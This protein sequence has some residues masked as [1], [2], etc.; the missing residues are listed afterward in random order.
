MDFSYGYY[1]S[2]CMLSR[3]LPRRM[4]YALALS[5]ADRYFL[6]DHAGREAVRSNLRTVLGAGGRTPGDAEISA[7]ARNTFRSFGKYLVDFF[8]YSWLSD[9]QVRR[10]FEIE[11]P[12]HLETALAM[13][14][15][16]LGVSA[17][18]GNWELSGPLL[19]ANGHRLSA[20]VLP[21][22]A[23]KVDR[24]LEKY[25]MR[26]GT[27]VLPLGR[28]TTLSIVG[29]LRRGDV[30][31]LMADKDFT[32]SDQRVPF[33]GRAARLPRGPAYLAV[34]TG[35]P[36]LPGFIVRREDDSFLLRYYP[37][38]VARSGDSPEQIQTSIARILEGVISEYPSQWF[39]FTD[40]WADAGPAQAGAPADSAAGG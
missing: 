15:G 5:I 12:E 9:G 6:R 23:E 28:G 14:R 3:A 21:Q 32:S 37:P 26:R 34:K 40:F 31:G 30:V 29:C 19:R 27:N 2:V 10:L 25:R 38:I 20:V 35:A 13:N 16:V 22:R 1:R 36:I 17:H 4:S 33:F 39:V 24:L 7:A 8:R 11:H 18:L